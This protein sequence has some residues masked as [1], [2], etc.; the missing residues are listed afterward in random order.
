M[1]GAGKALVYT[2][3][4]LDSVCTQSYRE[5]NAAEQLK[6]VISILGVM[7]VVVVDIAD[8]AGAN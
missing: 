8:A 5:R 7:V 1:I 6:I 2:D 3:L 4:T